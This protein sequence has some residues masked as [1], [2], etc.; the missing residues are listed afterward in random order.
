MAPPPVPGNYELEIGLQADR[1]GPLK[2]FGAETTTLT[3][4]A[5]E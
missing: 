3:V 2:S 4:T 1:V 5:W